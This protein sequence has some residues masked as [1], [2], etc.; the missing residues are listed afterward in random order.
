M[1][2]FNVKS[3]FKKFLKITISAPS[4]LKFLWQVKSDLA[5]ESDTFIFREL[6]EKVQSVMEV[7]TQ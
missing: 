6:K 4:D 7:K 1:Q 5:Y 3:L 2:R